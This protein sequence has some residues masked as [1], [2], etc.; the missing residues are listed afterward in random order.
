A[1]A[2]IAFDEINIAVTRAGKVIDCNPFLVLRAS[3]ARRAVNRR[4]PCGAVVSR[5]KDLDHIGS[6]KSQSREVNRASS[7]VAGQHRVACV[8]ACAGWQQTTIGPGGTAIGRTRPPCK[9]I[10]RSSKGARVVKASNDRARKR[11]DAGLALREIH[12]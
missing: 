3:L 6:R 5:T 7:T 4:Q 10:A 1:S 11:N 8:T 12:G 2:E 9:L